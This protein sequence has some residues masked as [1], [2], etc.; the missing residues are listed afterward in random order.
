MYDCITLTVPAKESAL[1]IVRLT[2]AGV[3]ARSE[4]DM[5]TLDDVKTAVYEACY[6]M[7]VQ[8]YVP[9][10][11]TICFSLGDP[12]AVSVCGQG[13]WRETSGRT[14]DVNLCNAVLSTMIP[15]VQVEMDEKAICCIRMHR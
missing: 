14:P 7:T 2:A 10:Q 15:H 13:D 5:E 12:F 1:M 8:K 9:E 4:M 6:A 11:L 3:A